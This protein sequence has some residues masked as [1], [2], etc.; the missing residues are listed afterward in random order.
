[1]VSE[2]SEGEDVFGDFGDGGL[3]DFLG[4]EE[5]DFSMG[6]VQRPWA[7]WGQTILGWEISMEGTE[8]FPMRRGRIR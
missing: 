1:M 7:F 8:S 5:G 3:G 2:V 4:E 6:R